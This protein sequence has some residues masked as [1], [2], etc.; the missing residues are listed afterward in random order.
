MSNGLAVAAA[1]RGL[2]AKISEALAEAG[3]L[4]FG[5]R[6]T[7]LRPNLLS[8]TDAAVNAFLFQITPNAALRNIDLPT[9]RAGGELVQRPMLALDLHYLLTFTGD[10]AELVPQRLLGLV[11]PALH[12]QCALSADEVT[13]LIQSNSPSYLDQ[14]DLAQQVEVVRFSLGAMNLEELS[15][16]WSVFFQ[17]QYL[18]SVPL[19]ASALLLEAPLTP[20][21]SAIVRS[22]GVFAG[23][24]RAPRISTLAPGFTPLERDG[25][26]TTVQIRGSD[27]IGDATAVLFGEREV[28]ATS[29]A[30][31]QLTV[32][33]PG[34]L[35]AGVHPVTVQVRHAFEQRGDTKT[36]ALASRPVPLAILPRITSPSPLS[37]T[38]G[39]IELRVAPPVARGQRVRVLL[40]R[41]VPT[42]ERR[43]LT[44]QPPLPAATEVPP[45][46]FERLRVPLPDRL[47]AGRYGLQVEVDGLASGLD[48]NFDDLPV[49]E[50][51]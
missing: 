40:E 12:A 27:L 18:L 21:P 46:E 1:T 4:G 47:A 22:R 13:R 48:L 2:C 19:Q 34:A 28:A 43:A 7:S 26:P 45:P 11:L 33:V 36:F 29:L 5:A 39:E 25:A 50:V 24:P 6:V 3:S 16:L 35:R 14:A 37:P 9:R 15:K 49:V 32:T 10:E 51:P 20:V 8:A 17:T 23:T 44:W 41:R 42:V 31:D 30:A 38:A